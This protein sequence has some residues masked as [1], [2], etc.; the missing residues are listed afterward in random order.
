MLIGLQHLGVNHH[1][2]DGQ[3][4][5]KVDFQS[6]SF[7]ASLQTIQAINR[8]NSSIKAAGLRINQELQ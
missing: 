1:G 2:N 8:S 7:S 5:N 3:M 4:E 6:E